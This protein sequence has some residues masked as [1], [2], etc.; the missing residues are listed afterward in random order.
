T[1]L[2]DSHTHTHTLFRHKRGTSKPI[3]RENRFTSSLRFLT[4]Q[5][6]N[7]RLYVHILCL[8]KVCVCVCV[9]VCVCVCVRERAL[10]FLTKRLLSD[11]TSPTFPPALALAQLLCLT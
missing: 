11:S 8:N 2:I 5:N 1:H 3:R 6:H 7:L 9:F 4:G 10:G